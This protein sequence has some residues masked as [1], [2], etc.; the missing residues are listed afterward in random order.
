MGVVGGL[1]VDEEIPFPDVPPLLLSFHVFLVNCS[2]YSVESDKEAI[3]SRSI[4]SSVHRAVA[5]LGIYVSRR[6]GQ[7][8]LQVHR[9]PW[10]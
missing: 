9:E 7:H 10:L 4:S 5:I 2:N 8:N 1:V 3:L 6:Q